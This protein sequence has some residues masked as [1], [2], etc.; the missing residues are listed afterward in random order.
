MRVFVKAEWIRSR[1]RIDCFDADFQGRD[2]I[3]HNSMVLVITVA[4]LNMS[5]FVCVWERES[6][7]EKERKGNCS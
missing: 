6:E 4:F 3:K 5:K 2:N 7:S 1:K